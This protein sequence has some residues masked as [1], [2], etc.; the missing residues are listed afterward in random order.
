[1]VSSCFGIFV[2]AQVVARLSINEIGERDEIR[3]DS[4]SIRVDFVVERYQFS[5]QS[6]LTLLY[7][8]NRFVSFEIYGLRG[9]NWE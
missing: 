4:R 1:M 2:F 5:L 3:S 8:L 9:M 6:S 7:H